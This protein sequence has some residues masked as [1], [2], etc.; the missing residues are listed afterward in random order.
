[1]ATIDYSKESL[2]TI[3]IRK[4]R[5]EWA[6]QNAN[7]TIEE[8]WE[9]EREARRELQAM[10]LVIPTRDPRTEPRRGQ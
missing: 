4:F 9:K 3:N 10:G 1:M 5:H 6:E 2:N 8:V 7:L